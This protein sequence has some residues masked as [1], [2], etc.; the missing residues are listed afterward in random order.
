MEYLV[1]LTDRAFRD[2]RAIYEFIGAESSESA[3]AWFGELTETIESLGAYPER[4]TTIPKMKNVRRLLF[5]SKPNVYGI[6]YFVDRKNK[7][8][9]VLHIRHGARRA[10]AS[11][12]T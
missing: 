3:L 4:G 6:G 8:V 2:M 5:G 12:R 9:R 7:I 1:K 11:E 10:L